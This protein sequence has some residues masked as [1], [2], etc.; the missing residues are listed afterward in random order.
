MELTVPETGAITRLELVEAMWQ[1]AG[2]PES[3]ADLSAYTDGASVSSDAVRWA[4]EQGVLLGRS[5]GALD[6]SADLT[7]AE[8][9]VLLDRWSDL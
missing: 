5:N 4:V 8:A 6:L 1:S 7:R 2:S 3:T 9:A